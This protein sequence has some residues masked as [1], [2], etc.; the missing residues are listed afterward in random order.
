MADEAAATTLLQNSWGS[1]HQNMVRAQ[2]GQFSRSGMTEEDL[3]LVPQQHDQL[4]LLCV[5]VDYQ[6]LIICI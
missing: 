2:L 5:L 1:E 4:L 3:I 6:Q